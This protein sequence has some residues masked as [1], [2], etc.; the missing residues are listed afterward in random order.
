MEERL[1]KQTSWAT[2]ERNVLTRSLRFFKTDFKK[3][4]I[5]VHYTDDRFLQK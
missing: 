2:E 5:A 3:K 4:W 1:A